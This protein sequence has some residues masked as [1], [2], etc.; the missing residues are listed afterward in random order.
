M[1]KE[2]NLSLPKLISSLESLTNLCGDGS[3]K[4]ISKCKNLNK[5]CKIRDI[6]IPADKIVSTSTKRI[7]DVVVAPGETKIDCL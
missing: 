4:S 3:H 2:D 5:K 7:Y 1:D 6:F